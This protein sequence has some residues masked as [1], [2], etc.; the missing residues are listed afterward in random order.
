LSQTKIQG[1]MSVIN[2]TLGFASGFIYFIVAVLGVFEVISRYVFNAPTMWTYEITT[3]MML[4]AIFLAASY[5]LEKGTHIK[6]ELIV[7]HLKGNKK[8]I[9]LIISSILGAVFCFCL[10]AVTLNL[11]LD[12]LFMGTTSMS[13]LHIPLFPIYIFMPV[14]SLL[15]FVQSIL[16]I[17]ERVKIK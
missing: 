7:Q 10:L 14:G 13:L 9:V 16:N 8:H 12:V 5:T 4:A 15:L 11:T 3:Y 1:S 17:L 6:V 2:K